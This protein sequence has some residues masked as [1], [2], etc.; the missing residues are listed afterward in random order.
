MASPTMVNGRTV[1]WAWI[2][3]APNVVRQAATN[4]TARPSMLSK[5]FSRAPLEPALGVGGFERTVLAWGVGR[6]HA[7]G[8][9]HVGQQA[10]RRAVD[11]GDRDAV[12]GRH[13]AVASI[14]ELRR[15]R[16]LA[17]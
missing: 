7:A 11:A 14:D 4:K 15:R 17:A 12:V 5:D 8:A 13:Q 1:S 10:V 6:A 9:L 2:G 3:T 16:G